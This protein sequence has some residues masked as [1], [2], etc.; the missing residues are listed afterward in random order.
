MGLFLF[1]DYVQT[2]YDHPSQ[3]VKFTKPTETI[4]NKSIVSYNPV[5]AR[6]GSQD[7][8]SRSILTNP[9]HPTQSASTSDRRAYKGTENRPI[10]MKKTAHGED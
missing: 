3:A 5:E 7:P 9:Y 8:T 10:R 6:P 1:N 4:S 2:G